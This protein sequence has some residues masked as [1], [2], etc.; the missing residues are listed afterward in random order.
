MSMTCFGVT[1]TGHED[2]FIPDDNKSDAIFLDDI[3]LS[4]LST[5]NKKK[6]LSRQLWGYVNT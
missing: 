3:V 6:L 4:E 1:L 5:S 2:G